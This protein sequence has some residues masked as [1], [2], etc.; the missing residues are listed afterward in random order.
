[1]HTVHVRSAARRTV[2]D[3]GMGP[4]I[5]DTPCGLPIARQ[6]KPAVEA[7][8][9]EVPWRARSE[10]CC[11]R[12]RRRWKNSVLG[13]VAGGVLALTEGCEERISDK[14]KIYSVMVIQ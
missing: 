5:G 11:E 9:N 12:R 6:R 3:T 7:T 8:K 2:R 4:T 13:G 14:G 10:K 1:V